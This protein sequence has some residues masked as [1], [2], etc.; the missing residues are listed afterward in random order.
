MTD[1]SARELTFRR[2]SLLYRQA[3]S[4]QYPAEWDD[5]P[6]TRAMAKEAGAGKYFTGKPCRKH[7]HISPLYT[8]TGE[9]IECRS[10]LNK[11]LT[12]E[13]VFRDRY[14]QRMAT[15]PAFA[16]AKRRDSRAHYDR[17]KDDPEF[18]ERTRI[19]N[20]AYASTP[21]GKARAKEAMA[22]FVASGK[23]AESDAR[24]AATARG[25]EVARAARRRHVEKVAAEAGKSYTAVVF[26]RNPQAR[27][28][29]RLNTR[30]SQALARE[31]VGK[32]SKTADLLGCSV[33]ELKTHL[34]ANFDEQMSWENYGKGP[35][36]WHV[37]HIRPCASFNLSDEEQQKTAFNWR[38]LLPMWGEENISKADR[39]DHEDE[40]EWADYMR[41][42]GFEG[43]LFLLFN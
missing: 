32:G 41:G 31:G 28:H 24:Y 3:V 35:G 43:E 12:G 25:Q 8:G 23:K 34:E 7:G 4:G 22:R 2:K 5:L 19:K 10:L 39:Y 16:E 38:N 13:G 15:D 42:L 29:S 26:E 9:C 33:A 17:N 11:R 6:L 27:L 30:I 20:R 21:E 36:S 14:A 40:A 18:M 1:P 37:D